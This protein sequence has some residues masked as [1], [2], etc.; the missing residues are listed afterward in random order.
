MPGFE[1]VFKKTGKGSNEGRKMGRPAHAEPHKRISAYIPAS[2][3][4]R[5]ERAAYWTPGKGAKLSKIV[6]RALLQHLDALEAE[7]GGVFPEI[8]EGV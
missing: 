7:R 4:D 5:L 3:A 2:L 8:P 6:E 1:D